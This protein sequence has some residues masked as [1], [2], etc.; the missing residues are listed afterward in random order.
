MIDEKEVVD[1]I[2]YSIEN[3]MLFKDNDD[4]RFGFEQGLK[5]ALIIILSEA[6]EQSKKENNDAY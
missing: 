3:N 1:F 5:Y 2:K 6:V 4:I